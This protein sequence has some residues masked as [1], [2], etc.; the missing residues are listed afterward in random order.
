MRRIGATLVCCIVFQLLAPTR[1]HA[2]WDWLEEFSGPG[3]FAG[4]DIEA[5][6]VCFRERIS[7]AEAL[8]N[9]DRWSKAAYDETP[10]SLLGGPTTQYF[11]G[12]R[13]VPITSADQA[14]SVAAGLR[15]ATT[16][17]A[18]LNSLAKRWQHLATAVE[19]LGTL[20]AEPE[21]DKKRRM[22]SLPVGVVLS[23]CGLRTI[24]RRRASID[25]GFRFLRAKAEPDFA[26]EKEIQLTTL[27]PSFTWRLT[28][29]RNHDFVDYG[30]GVGAYWFSS[31]GFTSH[32]GVF[33]EPIRLDFHAPTSVGE[34][35]PWAAL[36]MFRV[37][38]LVF[39]GGFE[40]DAFAA[41]SDVRTRIPR[42]KVWMFG[43][44]ADLEPLLGKYLNR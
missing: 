1:A 10:K 14:K 44:F 34:K 15:K 42:D 43:I 31:E 29:D 39:P 18:Q 19:D 40:P 23:A 33:L 16:E 20:L 4:P 3:W 17:F 32:N 21:P 24:E 37:G 27:E 2:W 13:L 26:S 8:S 30:V 6:L 9:I 7:R 41:T 36:P 22:A 28:S 11:T 12:D 25:L 5:R 35:Y 38:L